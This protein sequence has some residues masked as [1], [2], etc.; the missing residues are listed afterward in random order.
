MRD[1]AAEVTRLANALHN[2]QRPVMKL[3][4]DILWIIFEMLRGD[5]VVL[6]HTVGGSPVRC[7]SMPAARAGWVAQVLGVCKYW[8]HVALHAPSLWTTI[9]IHLGRRSTV[10]HPHLS[11]VNSGGSLLKVAIG[12]RRHPRAII[13][14]I[15]QQLHR[16]EHLYL[17]GRLRLEHQT[18][19]QSPAPQLRALAM[20]A[21]RQGH[22]RKA[23][24]KHYVPLDFFGGDFSSLRSLALSKINSF[25]NL[26]WNPINV[27][28]IHLHRLTSAAI[29]PQSTLFPFLQNIPNLE[30]LMFSSSFFPLA[31][32]D[33]SRHPRHPLLKLKRLAFVDVNGV[34]NIMCRLH[35][36]NRIALILWFTDESR[37]PITF[38]PDTS[39]LANIGQ[40]PL[41]EFT[42]SYRPE[43]RSHSIRAVNKHS[44]L[45]I[46]RILCKY[47]DPVDVFAATYPLLG[48]ATSLWVASN[49]KR[50][51]FKPAHYQTAF[52]ATRT[53]RLEKLFLDRS[54]IVGFLAYIAQPFSEGGLPFPVLQE[55]H[56]QLSVTSEYTAT[57]LPAL[58]AR[59]FFGNPIP[60]VHIYW[61]PPASDPHEQSSRQQR[62]LS[63][64]DD[65]APLVG[66]FHFHNEARMPRMKQIDVCTS[67][68]GEAW[69]WPTWATPIVRV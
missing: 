2:A 69:A 5:H 67:Q 63:A 30:D 65:L 15:L 42:F 3:S 62:Q 59:K 20:H 57:V 55:L 40:A 8:R 64:P 6:S 48:G 7:P 25:P 36:P 68:S 54:S 50:Y 13:S 24:A 41:E 47:S 17:Y 27:R 21:T 37:G 51:M 32:R 44:A 1:S 23:S 18:L 9:M 4:P 52:P 34:Y 26:H 14:E 28:Q 35:L 10:P 45:R 46:E 56:V 43:E 39:F 66:A 60:F 11:V 22:A 33:L 53:S 61:H 38:A 58:A 12:V 16:I 31:S 49:L 19:L 29:R